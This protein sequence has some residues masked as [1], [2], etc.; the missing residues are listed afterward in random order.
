[1]I[2]DRKTLLVVDDREI[3]IDI[4][5]S[6]L[7]DEYQI[8]VAMDGETALSL[9]REVHPDL[10]LLDVMLPDLDGFEVCRRLKADGRT[11]RIPVI[12]VTAL[13][14]EMDEARGLELGAVDYITRPFSPPLVMARIRN[15]LELERHRNNL[16]RLVRERTKDLQIAQLAS[17]HCMAT[18]AEARDSDTGAH[19]QRTR[20]YVLLL[21]NDLVKTNRIDRRITKREVDLMAQASP[22]HDV[23]KIGL[24]DRIL[25]KPGKLTPKEFDEMK[26]HT[27]YG[28]DILRNVEREMGSVPFLV[29]AREI[30]EN[31]HEKWDGSGYPRGLSGPQIPLSARIMAVADVYDALR[32]VRPYK[33]AFS[34][35]KAVCIMTE[36]SEGHFDPVLIERFFELQDQFDRISRQTK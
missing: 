26:L 5:L 22:L 30:A 16:E 20:K 10:I 14:Q 19:I 21:G 36:E 33:E 24:P 9:A 8:S 11:D 4:L 15:H 34:H 2:D 32:S 3:N 17:V 31:H 27:I 13:N 35:C 6:F 28:G 18:L 12:F 1:M 7:S 29:M 23:G 25:L